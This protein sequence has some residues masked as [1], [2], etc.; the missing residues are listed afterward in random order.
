M[1]S[2]TS[3]DVCFFKKGSVAVF[4]SI[5]NGSTWNQVQKLVAPD[6]TA[7]AEFGSSVA[8]TGDWIAVGA[9]LDNNYRADL[10]MHSS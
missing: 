10:G 8:V 6:G 5:N 4:R 3:N 7:G 1:I 2:N 9:Y